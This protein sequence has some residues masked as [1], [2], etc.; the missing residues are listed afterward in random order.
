[1]IEARVVAAKRS[2]PE[3]AAAAMAT[4]AAA[5]ACFGLYL[6]VM[7]PWYARQLATFGSLSPTSSSGYALWIRT[8]EEWNSITAAPSLARFLE[9]GWATIA[10]MRWSTWS[11]HLTTREPP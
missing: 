3:L 2:A 11:A 8:I 7:G 6:L 9:Q 10:T 4:V 1:M 5:V